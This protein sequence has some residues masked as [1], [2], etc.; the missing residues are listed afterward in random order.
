MD[1][2]YQDMV[3]GYTDFILNEIGC[4]ILVKIPYQ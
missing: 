3:P 2:A 4:S 1:S